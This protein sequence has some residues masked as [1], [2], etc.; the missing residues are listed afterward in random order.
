MPVR[1]NVV[2]LWPDVTGHMIIDYMI[3][4]NFLGRTLDFA[5]PCYW[6]ENH[7]IFNGI[8]EINADGFVLLDKVG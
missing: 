1:L 5:I 4:L 3:P 6:S 7:D 8:L 2:E